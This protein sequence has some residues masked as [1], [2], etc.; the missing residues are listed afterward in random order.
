MR[1]PCRS[2]LL[3]LALALL[4][5]CATLP[6]GTQ[7]SP[8]DPWERMNR[9]T[10]KFNDALDKAVL[11][12]VTRGYVRALPQV[13]RTGVSNLFDNLGTPITMVNDLLQGQLRGFANDTGRLILNTTVG[14]GG[15]LDPATKVGLDKN[16]RDFGQ[17]LGKWGLH[18]GPYLVIPVLGPSDVR[19]AAGRAGDEFAD[20]RHYLRNTW[21]R[22][23]LRGLGAVDTRARLLP[24]DSTLDG[25]YDPYGFVRNAYLQHRDF[26][27]SGGQKAETSEEDRL[28]QEAEQ[29]QDAPA[30]TAQPATPPAGA[31][32][33]AQ[34]PPR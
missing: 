32:P 12:P 15:L 16:D 21:L 13:V 1:L 33:P 24:L 6:P 23:G 34:P 26:K 4:G 20:P 19:D 11:R 31:T 28:Y 22:W 5:G 9:A 25:A 3:C 2:A 10:Y 29:Q 30:S 14:L 17:T 27:V 18:S 7:R 8:R